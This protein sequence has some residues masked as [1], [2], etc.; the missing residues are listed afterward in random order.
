MLIKNK[1]LENF[2]I[3][4]LDKSF[5]GILGIEFRNKYTDFI[6]VVFTCYLPPE[7]SPWENS[8]EFFG[9]LI[10]QVYMSSYAD[11]VF[12]CGDYNARV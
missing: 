11:L 2:H 12:L 8:T 5:E 4:I 10:S 6:F 7:N 9:H 1:L 3:N